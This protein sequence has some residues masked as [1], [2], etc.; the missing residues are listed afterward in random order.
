M[1]SIPPTID[2]SHICAG[3]GNTTYT[4][5]VEA[6]LVGASC[7]VTR[8]T[9]CKVCIDKAFYMQSPSDS[10]KRTHSVDHGASFS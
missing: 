2:S 7:G 9:W 1:R 4:L 3:C 5:Y 8:P 6:P 10:L